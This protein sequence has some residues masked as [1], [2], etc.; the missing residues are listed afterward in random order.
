MLTWGYSTDYT[1]GNLG[2]TSAVPMYVAQNIVN[3]HSF[4]PSYTNTPVV[5]ATAGMYISQW[6][7]P[8]QSRK[9]SSVLSA[10]G[11]VWIIMGDGNNKVNNSYGQLLCLNISSSVIN[12]A[13]NSTSSTAVTI[14]NCTKY[15]I[16]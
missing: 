15:I 16:V 10:P 4:K 3:G 7:P 14:A 8:T 9:W 6:A 1:P 13:D 5:Q 12:S 11:Y 2:N